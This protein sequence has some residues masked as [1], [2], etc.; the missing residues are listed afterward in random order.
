[1]KTQHIIHR[2]FDLISPTEHE[3]EVLETQIEFN[4]LIVSWNGFRP[5]VGFW[6]ISVSV[7][8]KNW[9]EY[10]PIASWG[11]LHQKTFSHHPINSFAR[12]YQDVTI[13]KDGYCSG[14]RIRIKAEQ[15]ATLDGLKS[16][17]ACFSRPGELQKK[18]LYDLC[19][20]SLE[21]V[22]PC[23]QQL[24]PHPRAKD[25]CSPTSTT[26]A[27]NYLFKTNKIDPVSFAKSAWDQ[28]FD[29]YGNWILNTAAAFEALEGQYH[30]CVA[31]LP[32]FGAIHEQLLKG[33]PVVVSIKGPI[34]GAPLPYAN[35]HLILITGYDRPSR[36]V[37]C[38]D[39]AYPSDEET[40]TSYPLDEF[41]TGWTDRRRNLSY[42]F[43]KLDH[44]QS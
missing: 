18:P 10:L 2:L 39:P 31:R 15:G 17:T 9:S 1:M 8:Q 25:L 11:A 43:E 23:S 5:S 41:L 12:T 27:I 24:L 13:I 3:I 26:A 40:I 35:G 21:L 34:A 28:A 32:D 42:L 33:L 44:L 6:T 7:F 16:I 36:S 20:V 22:Q 37:L 38:M 29:I 14:Y 4:E 19:S 30:T